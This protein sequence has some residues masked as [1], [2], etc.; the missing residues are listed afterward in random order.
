MVLG[1]IILGPCHHCAPAPVPDTMTVTHEK[2]RKAM[3]LLPMRITMRMPL[4]IGSFIA[5]RLHGRPLVTRSNRVELNIAIRS[6]YRVLSQKTINN[7]KFEAL[8][9]QR[10]EVRGMIS[11]DIFLVVVP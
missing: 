9:T 3:L 11:D 4:A 2:E 8:Y 1:P 5:C 10:V 6:A 7:T